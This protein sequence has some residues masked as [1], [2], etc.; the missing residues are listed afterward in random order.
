MLKEDSLVY[1]D[2]LHKSHDTPVPYPIM[3]HFVTEICM[4][5]HFCY[6]MVHCG[7][8][9]WCIVGYVR[10]V[11]FFGWAVHI[12]HVK[13]VLEIT[14]T[15]TWFNWLKGK[16]PSDM[17][18][19]VTLSDQLYVY[20]Y[21]AHQHNYAANY[22]MDNTK[23]QHSLSRSDK[24]DTEIQ[25]TDRNLHCHSKKS[26]PMYLLTSMVARL[27]DNVLNVDENM[28]ILMTKQRQF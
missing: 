11:Y 16:R 26:L 3:H 2:Q 28:F 10:W 24:L 27:K 9:D 22:N 25:R 17:L 4:C 13:H 18:V 5:A 21:I 23:S 19:L 15:L 1:I 12:L 8:W 14:L 6:K 20:T 7:I